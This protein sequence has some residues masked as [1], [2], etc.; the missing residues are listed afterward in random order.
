[1]N[2]L[3]IGQVEDRT[4]IDKQI[5]KQTIQPTRTILHVDDNPAVGINK[6]RERI[7]ENH[8]FLRTI[9]KAYKPDLVWQ[10]EG[11]AVLPEDTLERLINHYLQNP[12]MGFV[13][14][15]QVGRHGL[16][17]LGAWKFHDQDNFES[18]DYNLKGLQEVDATGFYCMLAP[19]KVWLA[20]KCQWT[21]EIYGPDVVFGLSIGKKKYVDMDLHI[22][23]KVKNGIINVSDMSTCNAKFFIED[24]RWKYKQL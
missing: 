8:Q 19:A 6:R 11:D 12:D 24:G 22:G 2:T 20:G 3:C 18:I 16:Y 15:V 23:H 1:M 13:S 17:C 14:G 5:L 4:N 10:V 7:A 21:G 9:V